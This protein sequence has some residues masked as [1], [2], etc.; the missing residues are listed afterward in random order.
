MSRAVWSLDSGFEESDHEAQNMVAVESGCGLCSYAMR[1]GHSHFRRVVRDPGAI[2]P[3]EGSGYSL[4]GKA[5]PLRLPKPG[6]IA[7]KA[8]H[9][10][11]ERGSTCGLWHE[12]AGSCGE[13][14]RVC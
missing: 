1:I 5:R 14:R 9:R 13:P 2:S 7:R 10:A 12:E 4:A 6:R 11:H 3:K 8:I